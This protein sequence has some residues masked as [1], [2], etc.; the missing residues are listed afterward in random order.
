M[1][2]VCFEGWHPRPKN[3]ST[4]PKAAFAMR[5][6]KILVER[7]AK[8]TARMLN[9]GVATKPMRVEI[10]IHKSK[11]GKVQDAD[12]LDHQKKV[13]LDGLSQPKGR[14]KVGASLIVDDS[15]EWVICTINEF[16]GTGFV[17]TVVTI[18]EQEGV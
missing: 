6:E 4:G 13:I 17:G 14:K 9:V 11:R 1:I 5:D 7:V 12:N 18:T 2:S 16:F 8:D 3:R 10:E 15:P